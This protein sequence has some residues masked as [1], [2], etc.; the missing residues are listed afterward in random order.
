MPSIPIERPQ[1]HCANCYEPL[2]GGGGICGHLLSELPGDIE[3]DPNSLS[4]RAKGLITS[5]S[6]VICNFC[7][8]RL[9]SRPGQHAVTAA[10]SAEPPT[11][12]TATPV[13]PPAAAVPASVT[14]NSSSAPVHV[15]FRR[16]LKRKAENIPP[17]KKRDD[18]LYKHF[19]IVNLDGGNVSVSCNHC[20]KF[21]KPSIQ[22][23]NPTLGRQHLINYCCGVDSETKRRL[24]QG[25]QIGRRAAES[26]AVSVDGSHTM[27]D[28]RALALDGVFASPSSSTISSAS[29]IQ[30]SLLSSATNQAPRRTRTQQTITS[31]RMFGKTMNKAE[32]DKIIM[33]EVRAIV[34]RGEPLSRLLDPYVKAALCARH[35]ALVQGNFIP[36]DRETIYN[37]YV[38]PVDKQ[39]YEELE[40][41]I[42]KLPGQINIS[43]DGAQVNSKQKVCRLFV[44]KISSSAC[45]LISL[46]CLS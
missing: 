28:L 5:P 17:K 11:A 15:P 31:D 12:A 40:S 8:E 2:H 44:E 41:Y 27:A 18:D 20:D 46:F 10:S 38:V 9:K 26:F 29:A 35:P 6:A 34:A 14:A 7:I 21:N 4:D 33:A 42:A 1:H 36:R 22:K 23:F 43:M 25:S 13:Q 45:E 37:N 16:V 39:A 30:P 24:S 19:T 3:I 32:A